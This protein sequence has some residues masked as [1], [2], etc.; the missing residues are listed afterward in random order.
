MEKLLSLFTFFGV[1]E[2]KWAGTQANL[3]SLD[4]KFDG[5]LIRS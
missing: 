3:I 1:V 4:R 2:E 5:Y